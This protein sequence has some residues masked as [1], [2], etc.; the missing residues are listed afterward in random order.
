MVRGKPVRASRTPSGVGAG[1]R[2]DGPSVVVGGGDVRPGQAGLSQDVGGGAGGG[3]GGQRWLVVLADGGDRDRL[4]GVDPL[5]AGGGL[6][7]GGAGPGQQFRL[8]ELGGVGGDDVGD[9]DLAGVPVGAPYGR[10]RGDG[11]VSEQSFLDDP[12]VDV[13]AAAD[14][15]VLGAAGE[16][17]EAVAVDAAEVAS[18]QPAVV[19]DVPA[20]DPGAAGARVGDVPSEHGG[21]AD[22]QHPGL[23]GVAVGPRPVA[24]SPDGLDLLSGQDAADRPS[25]LLSGRG[26]RGGA[27]GLSQPVTLQQALAGVRGE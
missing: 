22:H 16:V 15:E 4:D 27:G 23:G 11:G 5:G 25:P 26:E 10:R 17:D 9:R 24:V 1:H 19:D 20:A 21:A 12:G 13:V 14:D 8:V 18:V 2:D 3:V 6:A 7:D